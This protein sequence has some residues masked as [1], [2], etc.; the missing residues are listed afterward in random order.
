MVH[1]LGHSIDTKMRICK[2]ILAYTFTSKPLLLQALNNSGYP[3]IHASLIH[4]VP[5]N[6]ILAVLDDGRMA[7][8]LC[9]W[10]FKRN[11]PSPHKGQW[12]QLRNDKCGNAALARMGRDVG[13]AVCIVTYPGQAAVSDKMVATAVEA[14]MGEGGLKRVMKHLGFDKHAYLCG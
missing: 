5:K 11:Q 8:T 12:T 2:T 4:H 3:I 1:L 13:L 6:D 7:A 9:E 14:I 10:W